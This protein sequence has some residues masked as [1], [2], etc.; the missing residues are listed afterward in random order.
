M[1]FRSEVTEFLTALGFEVEK[2]IFRGGHGR[3]V[4]G[5][6]E[7]LMPAFQPFF[8]IV[9]ARRGEESAAARSERAGKGPVR[10]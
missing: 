3:G 5:L 9:A 2:V 8:S 7:R 1:L 10:S 4:V 6:A